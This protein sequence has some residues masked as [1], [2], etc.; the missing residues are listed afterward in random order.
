MFRSGRYGRLLS[1]DELKG[2]EMNNS[3]KR[4]M[5]QLVKMEDSFNTRMD[6]QD[7]SLKCIENAILA[8][9]DRLAFLQQIVR[10]HGESLSKLRMK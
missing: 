3:E 5:N 6:E 7:I 4:I 9:D 10:N 2:G 8:L 1:R